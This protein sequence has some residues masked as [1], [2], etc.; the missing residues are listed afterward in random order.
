MKK[1]LKNKIKRVNKSPFFE[2]F[3]EKINRWLFFWIVFFLSS[4]LGKHFFPSSSYVFGIRVDYLSPTIYFFDLLVVLVVFNNFQLMIDLFKIKKVLIFLFILFFNSFF[5]LFPLISFYKLA[6]II[7]WLIVF[8]F[9]K[10]EGG[11][12]LKTINFS[13]FLLTTLQ[14]FLIIIQL[15]SQ[16]SVGRWFWWLG[17]RTF[18][19]STPE[20][21]KASFDSKEILRPYGTFSHPNSL[22]GFFLLIY[23]YFLLKKSETW[24][25][26][27]T[28]FFSSFLIILS[29]S[30][31]ALSLW[32]IGNLVY[33]FKKRFSCRLCFF[34]RLISFL[35]VF[36]IFFAWQT[37][38]HSLS[39]RTSLVGEWWDL[40]L[41]KT[42]FGTGLGAY[43]K[44]KEL[45]SKSLV[46]YYLVV[47]PVHNVWFLL[48]GELGVFFSFFSFILFKKQLISIFK[49][50]W[51]FFLIIFISGFFDHYWWTLHQNFF[52]TAAIIG[53]TLF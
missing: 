52:L 29:F 40:F 47:Q 37:D 10:K 34:S 35:T 27:L 31:I 38:K 26:N 6:K 19:I 4:Q 36:L 28:L 12:Y 25:K 11:K 5:S 21:A 17:E 1:A 43:I 30:K 42:L 7:E 3:K 18:S 16:K 23:F 46:P 20:I 50:T 48:L 41:K 49:K 9:F 8:Y 24:I 45:L 22:A 32:I 14:F 2:R 15:F 51:P 39:N 13:F 44:G 53:L 33:Y